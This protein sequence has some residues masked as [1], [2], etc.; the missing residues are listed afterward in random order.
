[1]NSVRGDR[2]P[3]VS[4]RAL[5]GARPFVDDR[6]IQSLKDILLGSNIP[7]RIWQKWIIINRTKHDYV[8]R[9]PLT[10][11][12]LYEGYG[13]TPEEIEYN[14]QQLYKIEGDFMAAVDLAM[15]YR[16]GLTTDGPMANPSI[17]ADKVVEIVSAWS[18]VSTYST[19]NGSVL[20]WNDYWP[21]LLQAAMMVNEYSGYTSAIHSALVARTLSMYNGLNVSNGY[22]GSATSAVSNWSAVGNQ[23]RFAVATFT[24]N[25]DL[26]DGAIYRWRQQFNDSIKSNFLG[27]DGK[28]H[29]N[30][31]YHEIY[32][33]GSSQGDGSYGLLYSNYDFAAKA[34]GAEWARLGGEWI[35]DYVAPDGSSFEGLFNVI[36][37]WNRYPDAEHHWFNTSNPPA[38]FYSNQVYSGYD[39]AHAVFGVGNPDS[40]WIIANRGI[41]SVVGGVFEDRDHDF[42]RCTELLYRYR[43]IVDW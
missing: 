42:I 31:P 26:F 13:A 27:V 38:R 32:R 18:N 2:L 4:N 34:I 19:N 35:F 6:R 21:M 43:P 17:Y 22:D 15:Q 30:V 23:A 11:W 5:F 8:V 3:K 37:E 16:L 25:R 33:Q 28:Y 10:N 40:E 20:P 7:S 14:N 39:I 12:H 24:K 1:M 41:G 29:D 36:V 9:G